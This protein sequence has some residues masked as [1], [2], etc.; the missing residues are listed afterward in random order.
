[1]K[2]HAIQ[3]VKNIYY[4]LVTADDNGTITYAVPKL[5]YESEQIDISVNTSTI[6]KYTTGGTDVIND[7]EGGQIVIK[8]YGMDNV[9]VAEVEGHEIDSN[10]VVIEKSDDDSPYVAIGFEAIKRNGESRFVW[11]LYCKKKHDNEEYTKKAEK[12]DPK[13]STL[14]FEVTERAD[15]QWKNVIDSDDTNAPDDLRTKWFEKVYDGTAW[16]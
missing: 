9:T 3:D 10:G 6:K 4:A 11:L 16:A 12:T 8:T 2:K 15:K 7:F 14:T 1:M 5:L 13:S